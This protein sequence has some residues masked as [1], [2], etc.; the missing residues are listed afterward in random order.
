MYFQRTGDFR[1]NFSSVFCCCLL[2]FF[3]AGWPVYVCRLLEQFVC[4]VELEVLRVER[5]VLAA[6]TEI[7]VP[8]ASSQPPFLLATRPKPVSMFS[9]SAA[10]RRPVCLPP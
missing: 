2:V 8:T 5:R 4:F 7:N 10:R 1:C 6:A 9:S 3:L